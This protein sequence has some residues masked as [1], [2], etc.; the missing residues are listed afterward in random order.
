MST[1]DTFYP[2]LPPQYYCKPFR[3]HWLRLTEIPWWDRN[4]ADVGAPSKGP[5]TTPAEQCEACPPFLSQEIGLR[6]PGS[7]SEHVKQQQQQII[8]IKSASSHGTVLAYAGLYQFGVCLIC[9]L[10]PGEESRPIIYRNMISYI[11]IRRE[12]ALYCFEWA[13][14]PTNFLSWKDLAITLFRVV[15]N[16]QTKKPPPKHKEKKTQKCGDN[17]G[18]CSQ[19]L[20]IKKPPAESWPLWYIPQCSAS[21]F[22]ICMGTELLSLLWHACLKSERFYSKGAFPSCSA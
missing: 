13:V 19:K 9:L 5:W 4:V 16:K 12:K 6:E 11:I 3:E 22:L 8:D 17:L 18:I 14:S 21:S 7:S 1:F 10:P 15:S 2:T 20:M